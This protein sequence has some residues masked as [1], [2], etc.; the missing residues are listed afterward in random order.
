MMLSNEATTAVARAIRIDARRMACS[1]FDGISML[2]VRTL[3]ECL[4]PSWRITNGFYARLLR[5]V[6]DAPVYWRLQHICG[7]AC[8]N[9]ANRCIGR[10][11]DRYLAITRYVRRP[12][13]K[14][15]RGDRPCTTGGHA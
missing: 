7:R 13:G 10:A 11:P 12:V 2:Q 6:E 3:H 8:M 4:A 14:K 15:A 1:A 9:F 5:D